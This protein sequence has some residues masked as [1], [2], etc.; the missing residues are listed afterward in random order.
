MKIV[1]RCFYEAYPPITGAASVT[2]FVPADTTLVQLGV[3]DARFVTGEGL[4]VVTIAG[5]SESKG[6][7]PARLPG[8]IKRMVT[9]ILLVPSQ[10]VILEGAYGPPIAL[11]KVSAGPAPQP[12]SYFTCNV[13]G[14]LVRTGS[15]ETVNFQGL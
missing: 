12:A 9:E 6:A 14:E 5:A 10:F 7:R 2:R 1:I 4:T 15:S 13:D 8:F 11:R 3:R